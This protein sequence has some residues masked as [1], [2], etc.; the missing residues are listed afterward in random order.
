MA[1]TTP[2]IWAS[3]VRANTTD[4]PGANGFATNTQSHA[5]VVGLPDGGYFILWEDWSTV[6]S[7]LEPRD[8]VGQYFD[9]L[10][11]KSGTEFNVS[12]IYQDGDQQAPDVAALLNGQIAGAYQTPD[13]A[14]AGDLEN[15]SVQIY[16]PGAVAGRSDDFR[17]GFGGAPFHN[18][19]APAI[20]AF[21][22]G[23]Y[24]LIFENDVAGNKDLSTYIVSAAGVKSA[25]I[26][27]ENSAANAVAPDAATLT[28]GN[29][30]VAYQID[31]A[32]SDIA[33][34]V[35]SSSNGSVTTGTV[36]ST[37]S[38]ETAPAIASL[39]GGGFV[40]VWGDAAGD[41]A[42]NAGIKAR[43]YA[44]DG[45]PNAVAFAVNTTTAGVQNQAAVTRLL[46]GGF[47]VAWHDVTSK[48]VVGQR[49]DAV[50][51]KVGSQFSI[52]ALHDVSEPSLSLLADGRV[53][54]IVTDDNAGNKDVYN[55]IL[56]PRT[57]VVGTI[58]SETLTSRVDGTTVSGLGG[59]DTLLGFGGKDTLD[60]GIGADT[61]KG[62]F[63]DDTYVLGSE[64]DIVIDT[65]G[66]DTITTTITRSLASY[67]M[68]EKLTLLGTA[69][70]SGTG[71]G[72]ANTITGNAAANTLNGGTGND[73][74]IGG[75]GSDTYYVDSAT[76]II[77]ETNAVLATGGTDRV[78]STISHTLRTNVEN[79]YLSGALAISGTGNTLN[80]ILSGNTAANTLNGLAGNDTIYGGGG[81]DRLTGGTGID[82]FVF[83][84][85][86]NTTTNKDTITDFNAPQDSIKLENGIFTGLGLA[87][88]TLA[89]AKFWASTTG[90]AHD[91][92]DRIVYNT[93][94][95]VLTYDSNGSAAG[96]SVQ[97]A[98][99]TTHPA[100]TNADFIVI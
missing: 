52:A 30:V 91:A 82:S 36:A 93:T 56:D 4:A 46:D 25:E 33:F 38:A 87:V 47:L 7:G 61:L 1:T 53:V 89:S 69:A 64:S 55:V 11:A 83:S 71:N 17:E 74:M 98:V 84:T 21:S 45:T 97:F 60:G 66:I 43:V 50:G 42:A 68:L 35:R 77:T 44:V 2:T 29:Y 3:L 22:D 99:L 78:F 9:V 57:S 54:A 90:V 18:D 37:S 62:G 65:G 67:T 70:I 10:G 73:T 24:A 15:I 19:T 34:A 20:T 8:I 41:G 96:G 72:L 31:N 58:A 23:S 86:A 59:N 51:A 39:T 5:K 92:D 6:F 94:T 49:F 63:G 95:G 13:A 79:L 76:D 81:N 27:I 12:F 88:G 48:T 16:G 26:K 75:N 14:G 28:N 40:V 32:S 100:I 80:N 85:L